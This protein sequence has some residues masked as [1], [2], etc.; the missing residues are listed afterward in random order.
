MAG[1]RHHEMA[2]GGGYGCGSRVRIVGLK[3]KPQFNRKE[4]TALEWIEARG[5]WLV[6]IDGDP[7]DHRLKPTNLEPI[8]T[9]TPTTAVDSRVEGWARVGATTPVK[10]KPTAVAAAATP[11]PSAPAQELGRC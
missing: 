2:E 3:A 4:G 11:V 1:N 10:T 8:K 9:V 6:R 7:Q 5:R